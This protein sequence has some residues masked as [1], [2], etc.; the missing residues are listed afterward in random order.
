MPTH[1]SNI[2]FHCS[3]EKRFPTHKHWIVATISV[4]P[5]LNKKMVPGS[6]NV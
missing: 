2:A 6:A 3:P 5:A 4:D 1:C